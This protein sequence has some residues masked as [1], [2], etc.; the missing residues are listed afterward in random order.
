MKKN[1]GIDQFR[2]ILAMMVIAIHCLPLHDIWPDGDLLI[3]LTLF[4][5]AVPF[6][7]MISGYYVFSDLATENRYPARRKILIFIRKQ[8]HVYFWAILIF[9]PLSLYSQM[10]RA[11]L[12]IGDFFHMLFVNGTL[13]HL[14]YF[15]ALIL[16]SLLMMVLLMWLPFKGVF[17]ICISLY[18]I[19]LGGDSWYGLIDQHPISPI[20]PAIFQW[21]GGTRNGLFFTPMFLLLGIIAKK[22]RTHQWV[23][24]NF[25]YLSI[26]L[27]CLLFESYFL[28]HF[29]TPKHDSMYF[30]L[31]FVMFFLFPI[32]QQ[33]RPRMIWKEPRKC[34]LWLYLLHPYAIA[35]THYLSRKIILLQNNLLNYFV[36]ISLTFVLVHCL[37]LLHKRL[38]PSERNRLRAKR[39]VKE[40]SVSALLHNLAA[41]KQVIDPQTKIMAVVKANAYG[42]DAE[43]M[44]K[45]LETAGV[46]FFAVATIDEAIAL[47]KSG[48]QSQLLILGYTSPERINEIKHYSLTQTI[49]SEAHAQALAQKNVSIECHLAIDTGMHRL[50]VNPDPKTISAIYKL[51]TLAISGIFSHLG[52]ADQLDTNSIDR[53]KKQIACF[54]ALLT[55]LRK[56]NISYGITH[57]QSSY[58]I[59]NYPEK[60][61]D[62]VRPGILLTGSLSLPDQPTKRHLELQPV[63]TIKAQLIAKKTIPAGEAIGYGLSSINQQPTTIGIVSIGYADGLP[64]GLSSLDFALVYQE[65][66]LP[67]IGLICMDMLIIDLTNH[68]DIAIESQLT[69]ITDWAATAKQAQ[70][71][72][73]DLLSRLGSRLTAISR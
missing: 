70:T 46:D 29:S 30:F 3:T 52:S 62:Y 49:V 7:F 16:G 15:P 20:Y 32:I 48:T 4:R 71:I 72:S 58:G 41:I 38:Q 17:L 34:S 28:H 5:I 47:R 68:P 67:Q 63:L 31:P 73:N 36:V 23:T 22:N 8:C 45:V 40:L 18:V 6:F 55:V 35:V 12:S 50:G 60:K 61:Y 21:L 51:P 14:W 56:K 24:S 37:L 19:G 39:A 57:L 26:S 44:A 33:W 1:Q 69:V 42:C 13:Y 54:D 2:V 53:T 66:V 65:K 59:L 64:R 11:D 43:T 27:L 9:L 10:I 25:F